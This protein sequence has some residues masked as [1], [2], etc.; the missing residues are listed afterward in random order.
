MRGLLLAP[1]FRLT[2]ADLEAWFIGGAPAAPA[3]GE[4]RASSPPVAEGALVT[5]TLVLW[6]DGAGTVTLTHVH[7]K[8]WLVV[9]SLSLVVFGLA[10]VRLA[11]SS[12]PRR[13]VW[14]CVLAALAVLGGLALV[15]FTPGLAGL[16]AYG[17]QPGLLVLAV[18]VLV[19]WMLHERSRRQIIFLP[20]F[21][22]APTASSV[23]QANGGRPAEP[24]TV[25]NPPSSSRGNPK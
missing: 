10:L 15:V 12:G 22:R 1:R 14:A 21:S 18:L 19:Q 5:P 16:V 11:L 7:Q 2:A 9:C 20:S 17:C 8:V 3:A 13:W 4:R 24:S 23:A 25:D 6:R